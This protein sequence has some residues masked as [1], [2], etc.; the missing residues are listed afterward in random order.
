[1]FLERMDIAHP[2]MLLQNPHY[3]SSSVLLPSSEAPTA[4][5]SPMFFLPLQECHAPK[6]RRGLQK[7]CLLQTLQNPHR[8]AQETAQGPK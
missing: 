6:R 1:M 2:V 3:W 7:H 8:K 4:T 5:H